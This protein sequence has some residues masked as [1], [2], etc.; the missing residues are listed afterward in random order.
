MFKKLLNE[1][2]LFFFYIKYVWDIIGYYVRNFNNNK[3]IIA[4]KNYMLK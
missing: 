4:G 3:I 1:N 2:G